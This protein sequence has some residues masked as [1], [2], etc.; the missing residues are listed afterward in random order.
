VP[1]G[2]APEDV[3][4]EQAVALLEARAIRIAEG[5]GKR[6]V[7]KKAAKKKAT[8]ATARKRA[9]KKAK[10]ASKKE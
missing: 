5:G 10:K 9:T 8:K 2:T 1:R 4:V 6:P 7:R 3:S